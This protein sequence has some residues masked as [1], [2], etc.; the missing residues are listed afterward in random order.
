M[1][2]AE[3]RDMATYFSKHTPSYTSVTPLVTKWQAR[4]LPLSQSDKEIGYNAPTGAAARLGLS[5][6]ATPSVVVT[7]IAVIVPV[8]DP[9]VI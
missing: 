1:R 3:P 2:P 4:C 9:A 7:F 5:A 6:G 8:T